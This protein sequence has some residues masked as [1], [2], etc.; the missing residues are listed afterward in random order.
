MPCFLHLKHPAQVQHSMVL[1]G[2]SVS[3]YFAVSSCACFTGEGIVFVC[4]GF[5][6]ALEFLAILRST[7]LGRNLSWVCK[8]AGLSVSPH[9]GLR[10][11]YAGTMFSEVR[12]KVGDTAWENAQSALTD[13]YSSSSMPDFYLFF[14]LWN[15]PSVY[16][17]QL[18]KEHHFD[19][20]MYGFNPTVSIFTLHAI[21][22]HD[23]QL[24]SQKGQ[25]SLA[26]KSHMDI[27][28]NHLELLFLTQHR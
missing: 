7:V 20:T 25:R 12:V 28:S 11:D 3:T 15:N 10:R 1:C 2:L 27:P 26:G 9:K 6:S 5:A 19:F 4:S 23:I 17:W 16:Q 13:F 21:H 18:K 22:K 24:L 8:Q 14:K